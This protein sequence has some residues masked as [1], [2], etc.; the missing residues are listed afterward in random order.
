VLL[1]FELLALVSS[2]VCNFNNVSVTALFRGRWMT[3]MAFCLYLNRRSLAVFMVGGG[4]DASAGNDVV[5]DLVC[6][7][8]LTAALFQ[9]NSSCKLSTRAQGFPGVVSS[10][11]RATTTKEPLRASRCSECLTHFGGVCGVSS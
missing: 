9:V 5:V 1:F 6:S 10:M 11:P 3:I 7:L 2:R 8:A 4:G